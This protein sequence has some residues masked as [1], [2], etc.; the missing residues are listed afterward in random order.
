MGISEQV[1]VLRRVERGEL[2]HKEAAGL[3]EC[4]T[5]TVRR[6]LARYRERGA[7][8]LVHGLTGRRSN[9]AKPET[10]KEEIVALYQE[11]H[12][13]VPI[14]RFVRDVLSGRQI[15]LSRE[16]VR[17]WLIEAGLWEAKSREEMFQERLK[18]FRV[19]V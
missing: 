13:G 6:R 2:T 1:Q 15:E 5:R 8:G 19:E 4:S 3:L 7:D 12:P 14:S 16:T 17:R 11:R 10:L 9:R 18:P